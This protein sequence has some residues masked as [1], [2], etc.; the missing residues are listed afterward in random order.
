MRMK[1]VSYVM[2]AFLSTM[3]AEP[4]AAGSMGVVANPGGQDADLPVAVTAAIIIMQ[5]TMI[6]LP[7]MMSLS[8]SEEW[9]FH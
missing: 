1:V 5:M 4:L 2:T 3:A 9:C 6:R 7:P 8:I